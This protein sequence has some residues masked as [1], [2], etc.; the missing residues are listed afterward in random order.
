MAEIT[1]QPD[2]KRPSPQAQPF[3]MPTTND[4]YASAATAGDLRLMR[5]QIA[6]VLH[7]VQVQALGRELGDLVTRLGPDFHIEHL[8][9]NRATNGTF[10]HG[11][12]LPRTQFQPLWSWL[13]SMRTITH[14]FGWPQN[15]G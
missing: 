6:G 3:R 8:G 15:P 9:S 7:L 13:P 5:S 4:S 2:A 12:E 14:I 11:K 10:V 1:G